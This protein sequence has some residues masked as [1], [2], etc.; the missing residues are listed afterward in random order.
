MERDRRKEIDDTTLNLSL[1]FILFTLEIFA[2]KL[3]FMMLMIIKMMDDEKY[4]VDDLSS[5]FLSLSP[6]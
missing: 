1:P 2:L 6:G 3:F 5:P 4:D